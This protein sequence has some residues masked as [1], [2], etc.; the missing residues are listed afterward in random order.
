MFTSFHSL[1]RVRK[2]EVNRLFILLF[3]LNFL[4]FS[5]VMCNIVGL[6]VTVSV[7]TLEC[8]VECHNFS[9]L[10]VIRRV[11]LMSLLFLQVKEREVT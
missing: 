2:I 6:C 8:Q 11:L 5:S 4:F 9:R 3:S 7:S 1:Y 10:L